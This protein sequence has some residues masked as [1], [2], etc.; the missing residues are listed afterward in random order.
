MAQMQYPADASGSRT[1]NEKLG[2][3][4][5]FVRASGQC[6]RGGRPPVGG[7]AP[8]GENN[9]HDFAEH[10]AFMDRRPVEPESRAAQQMDA[11]WPVTRQKISKAYEQRHSFDKDRDKAIADLLS[12]DQKLQYKKIMDESDVHRQEFYKDR[13]QLIHEAEGAEPRTLGR[14]AGTA[15]GRRCM[16]R[17]TGPIAAVSTGRD[18]RATRPGI[19]GRNSDP[20]IRRCVARIV[21]RRQTQR[22]KPAQA[23][24]E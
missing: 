10:A 9:A 3:V 4:S 12:E 21:V 22:L 5:G 6:R 14:S 7:L 23:G 15:P 11:I 16:A 8:S 13:D 1:T 19:T 2:V 18:R 20:I 24:N 17:D